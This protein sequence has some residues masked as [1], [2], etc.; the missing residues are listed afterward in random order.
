MQ[1]QIQILVREFKTENRKWKEKWN[2]K[3]GK[4]GQ[5][6][7]A[8]QCGPAASPGHIPFRYVTDGWSPRARRGESSSSSSVRS[9]AQRRRGHVV[10]LSMPINFD[11]RW[12]TCQCSYPPRVHWQER[13]SDS[14]PIWAPP[15]PPHLSHRKQWNTG[16][17]LVSSYKASSW[18]TLKP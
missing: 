7:K 18:V 5:W 12:S 16:G 10:A 15:S 14:R 17:D 8:H 6:T 3:K 9:T 4:T 1:K 13:R 2:R 11:D